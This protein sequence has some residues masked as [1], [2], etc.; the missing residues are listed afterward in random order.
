MAET[1]V[2]DAATM[3]LAPEAALELARSRAAQ[4]WRVDFAPYKLLDQSQQTKPSGRVDHKFVFERSEALGEARIRLQLVVTGDE[5]TQ[6]LPFVHVPESFERR[7]AELRS[8]N[9]AIAGIAS[10]SAGV[11]YGLVGCI[12]GALW[13]LRQHWLVWKPPL[14]AGLV[15]GALLGATILANSPSAWF[16]FSTTQDES[17]FWVRQVGLALLA[18]VGGGLA[19]GEVFMAAEGLTR[20]AFPHHPQLWH[21]WSRDAGGTVE[22]AGRTA[23][24]YLFVPLELA[25]IAVF[26]Y[27][28]NRWLG[29]WQPSEALTDP[30][31]LASLVPALTPISISLQAGFM[32]ECVFRAV[33][34]ALGALIGARFGRRRLG[35]AI[36]FVLQAVIFGAVHANYPGLPSY[37]RLVELLLPSLMWAAIFL[38]YGLLPTILLHAVFDLVLIS[39]P[40]FL[41]DAP[42]A[43]TQRALVIAAGLVPALVVCARRLQRGAWRALPDALRNGAWQPVVPA[44][45]GPEPAAV[46]GR[47]GARGARL[48]RALP[49]AGVAGLA[50]WVAFT[51]RVADAPPLAIDRAAAEA[52]ATAALAAN[53]VTLGPEWRRFAVPRIAPEDPVQRQ[54]HA[55][56]WREAGAAQYRALVGTVL[57]PPLWEVRF[58]R[59]DGNVAERAEEWR[60]TVTGDA[61][62]RGLFHRLPEGRAGATLERDAAQALAGDAL[63]TRLGVDAAALVPRVAEQEKRPARRDWNFAYADPRIEVGTGGEARVQVLVAGDEPVLVGRS[64]FVPEAWQRAEAETRGPATGIEAGQPGGD[65]AGRGRGARPR[66]ARVEQGPQRPACVLVGLRAHAADDVRGQRQ[67]LARARDAAAHRRAASG[68]AVAERAR[69]AGRRRADGA[70]VRAPGGSR[71]ALCARAGRV[72]AGGTRPP[73][74]ARRRGGA[75]RR[76]HRGGA[77][78]AGARHVAAVAR[79]EVRGLRVAVRGCRDGRSSPWFPRWR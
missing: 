44:P 77:G 67:Q 68:P 48:Q 27:A 65:R 69:H 34:L 14:V 72:P 71:R 19:L 13:L 10:V 23:G 64:L 56:V 29:W 21:L 78:H 50:A 9:T 22:V 49:W 37:S 76:R 16:G 41:I 74:A 28:T 5:L 79:R 11:L 58:A 55:F 1:H 47:I 31:I 40:L 7:F 57:A 36:A 62:I 26:Y 17:T 6:V 52:A 12:L 42:G 45:S 3:A 66:G 38:R 60:V 24:G 61:R 70:A 35:I 39:I 20:R 18:F 2:R 54:W 46:A 51:P 25:L 75:G 59:F 15:I 8:T 53:G 33:P 43:W 30:N 4:D 73:V 63:R 32:E